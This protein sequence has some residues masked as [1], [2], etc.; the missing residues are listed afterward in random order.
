MRPT[1]P[2]RPPAKTRRR[3]TKKTAPEKKDRKGGG[4]TAAEE[5]AHPRA[6]RPAR[7]HSPDVGQPRESRHSTPG[8]ARPP[9]H[10]SFAGRSAAR[11]K[12][13]MATT[14]NSGSTA[15]PLCAGTSPSADASCFSS[16]RAASPPASAT[17]C[18]SG[19]PSSSPCSP[20]PTCR[21]TIPFA[22]GRSS[23]RWR[24]WSSTRS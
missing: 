22:P 14:P 17:V 13:I 10:C 20:C 3:G 6:D 12:S 15:S 7:P 5:A 11:R 23:A 18:K 2:L 24:T 19:L 21:P 4:E 16:T 8:K 1:T 9:T